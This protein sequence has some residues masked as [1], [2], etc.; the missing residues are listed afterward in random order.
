MKKIAL[1]LVIALLPY[2]INAQTKG[3]EKSI[4]VYSN[5]GVGKYSNTAFGINMIN[6]YRFND[7]F[8][9][10]IGI[11]VSYHS[12]I[13]S[14]FINKRTFQNDIFRK[15]SY[16]VPI[17]AHLRTDLSKSG[18]RPFLTFNAGYT[19]DLN[20]HAPGLMLE[21]AFGVEIPINVKQSILLS[22]GFNLQRH[23]YYYSYQGLEITDWE[24]SD[25]E[26]LFK[27]IAVKAAIKF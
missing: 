15:D 12:G 3:Y 24:S 16:P 8:Y 19:I 13:S 10:G 27:A 20:R 23:K 5:I 22:V 9:A 17:Y 6:G 14:V 4:G 11:G 21:P 7:Y 18:V 1:I 26:E 25:K 2:C